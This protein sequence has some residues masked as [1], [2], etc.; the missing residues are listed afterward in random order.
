MQPDVSSATAEYDRRFQ[1]A[2]HALNATALVVQ[3]A[4]G[5]AWV[6]RRRSGPGMIVV[7][8]ERLH[9]ARRVGLLASSMNPLTRAH[10]ALAEAARQHGR[11]NT[12][13]W[14]A[15][16]VT[17]DKEQ[18]ERASQADRLI[19][20]Q[21]HAEAT[22]DGLLL[23]KGGLY[24]EQAR[25]AHA[26]LT[27]EAEVALIVGFD[28][29][30]QI[31]D[32]RYYT[33]RDA[34]LRE[35]FSEAEL[36]VAPRA[37]SDEADLRALL[38]RPENHEFAGR[39]RFCPLSARYAADSSSE[40]R[41]VV[42]S[43]TPFDEKLAQLR[44]LLTPEGLA[45]TLTASPYSSAHL[46]GEADL[47]DLYS[48]REQLVAAFCDIKVANLKHAPGLSPLVRLASDAGPRGAALRAW[49]R[50]RGKHTLEGLQAALAVE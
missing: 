2:L 24:V 47:G 4:R 8:A 42:I 12:L 29:V 7:G 41:A 6:R 19:Q 26:L 16:A 28:K 33:D 36:I 30:V 43:A 13:A 50:M 20:A 31:F 22:G 34:A 38:D 15:T 17:V 39:V 18:V 35:L 48:A 45:L 9:S 23:L 40:A 37:G 46:P 10:V 5:V 27:P 1:A 49:V 14:V 3:A 44:E 25:A 11:L 32:P 21:S